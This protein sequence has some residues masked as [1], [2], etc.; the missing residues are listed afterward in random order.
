M[1]SEAAV[2]EA[3]R[4]VM[5]PE[6][7]KDIVTLGMAKNIQVNDG[8]VSLLVTLTTPACPLQGHDRERCPRCARES[9]WRHLS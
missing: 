4:G 2:M 8:S 3:L 1:A 7:H 9:S 5:D 6:L